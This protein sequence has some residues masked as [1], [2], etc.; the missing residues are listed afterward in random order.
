MSVA[1]IVILILSC[2]VVAL[3]LVLAT[4]L[5]SQ[6]REQDQHSEILFHVDGE[7]TIQTP[8]PDIL[9]AEEGSVATP[10]LNGDLAGHLDELRAFMEQQLQAQEERIQK[11]ESRL[12][13]QKGALTKVRNE[14]RRQ[15]PAAPPHKSGAA[16]PKSKN[17]GKSAGAGD[18]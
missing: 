16:Q 12:S 6:S 2:L 1:G 4:R 14:I 11:L 13:Y 7:R 17:R 8:L 10:K 15:A 18:S 9:A 3:V 5:Y